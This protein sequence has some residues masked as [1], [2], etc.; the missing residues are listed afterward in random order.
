MSHVLITGGSSGIGYEL[1]QIYAAHGYGLVLASRDS[2]KL[3]AELSKN[4]QIEYINIDLSVPGSAQKLHQKVTQQNIS[5]SILIN[6]AGIGDYALFGEANIKKLQTMMHLNMIT[7][8]EL[9]HLFLPDVKKN[10]GKIINLASTAAFL[11]GPNMAIY[12]ATKHFVLAFSEALA[13]E[14]AE[15]DVTV[16]AVCPGPTKSNFAKTAHAGKSSLFGAGLPSAQSV[17]TFAYHASEKGKRIA[18]HRWQNRLLIVVLRLLPRN[19]ITKLV[20]RNS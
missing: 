15:D 9:T 18:I 6:N 16:T 14:L 7:L 17:A 20:K 13:E 5:V 1:A 12:Y 19:L 3:P 4:I 11:P 8:T 10:E 2:K